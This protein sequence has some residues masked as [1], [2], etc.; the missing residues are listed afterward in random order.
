MHAA[1][2]SDFGQGFKPEDLAKKLQN[3]KMMN[4]TSP[5][6]VASSN[7]RFQQHQKPQ[8]QVSQLSRSVSGRSRPSLEYTQ[9]AT[10]TIS[11]ASPAPRLQTKRSFHAPEAERRSRDAGFPYDHVPLHKRSMSLGREDKERISRRRGHEDPVPP[12][13]NV[14]LL[15]RTSLDDHRERGRRV[16]LKPHADSKVTSPYD[17]E[18]LQHKTSQDTSI[19]G[20]EGAVSSRHRI[21]IHSPQHPHMVD[22][23]TETT[24]GDLITSLETEG[25]LDGWAGLG[26]WTIWEIAQD[27]GMGKALSAHSNTPRF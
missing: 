26:G 1:S 6:F 14:A 17:L 11:S 22:I 13:P 24:A 9:H 12:L 2:H 3:V 20:V 5:S 21:F 18:R 19:N 10:P 23:R 16:L 7:M 27:F 8:A 4:E 25:I 15:G